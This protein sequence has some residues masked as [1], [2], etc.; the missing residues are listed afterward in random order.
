[1][2]SRPKRSYQIALKLNN[3]YGLDGRGPNAYAR[4]VWCFG[5]HARAWKER[6]IFGKIRYMNDQGLRRKFKIDSYVDAVDNL[7]A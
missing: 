1:M 2:D 4:V 6:E 5:K 7:V 3:K